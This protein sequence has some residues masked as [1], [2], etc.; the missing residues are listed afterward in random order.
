MMKAYASFAE[1]KKDQSAK[2]QRLVGALQRMIKGVAPHLVTTVKWGQGCFVDG[3]EP[4][5]Y[6]HAE[7]DHLQL[8]FYRGASLKD[9]AKLL[10]GK[11]KYVRHVKIRTPKDIDALA[12]SRLIVQVTS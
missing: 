1:W 3:D 5:L 6:I 4:K 9:P 12:L 10:A 7:P 11:G 2:H 8:G